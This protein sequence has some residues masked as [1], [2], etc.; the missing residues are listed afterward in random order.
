MAATRANRSVQQTSPVE[1]QI[2]TSQAPA[3]NP[4]IQ[5]ALAQGKQ[6]VEIRANITSLYGKR[7]GKAGGKVASIQT[8]QITAFKKA[9]GETYEACSK[10]KLLNGSRIAMYEITS[11]Y[12]MSSKE[13]ATAQKRA[14]R[15]RTPLENLDNE[16]FEEYM[17]DFGVPYTVVRNLL[18][19][20]NVDKYVARIT[21]AD[22]VSF[23]H[24]VP[25]ECIT[26]IEGPNFSQGYLSVVFDIRECHIR[27]KE[28]QS[29]RKGPKIKY[30]VYE[31]RSCV[32]LWITPLEVSVVHTPNITP[33]VKDVFPEEK[34]DAA[35]DELF[36]KKPVVKK[37]R[38]S[39][40]AFEV[41]NKELRDISHVGTGN[42]KHKPY[43]SQAM[44]AAEKGI[45][46]DESIEILVEIGKRGLN[47]ACTSE[48][49]EKWIATIYR[50]IAEFNEAQSQVA[51]TPSPSPV[52][53]P[54]LKA[55]PA[56]V[57]EEVQD[58]EEKEEEE[59]LEEGYEYSEKELEA[60]NLTD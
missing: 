47:S 38:M 59:D 30:S 56:L 6:L 52:P 28:D 8:G 7:G 21:D 24:K 55:S 33:R 57:S 13:Y 19:D 48:Q 18:P 44:S 42:Q 40:E 9:N 17:E 51:S 3:I 11:D 54:K 1:T 29:N 16:E 14:L 41:L 37:N 49:V 53:A 35:I 22:Y 43:L 23:E 34:E 4:A 26:E 12:D 27:D 31:G 39:M 10:N 60:L 50:K 5:E 15:N 20:E 36:A 46:D 45:Y 58:N 2:T 32:H 25:A